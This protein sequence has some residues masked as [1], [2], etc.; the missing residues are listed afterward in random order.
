MPYAY[1]FDSL[2]DYARVAR[3]ERDV[4]RFTMP[5]YDAAKLLGMTRQGLMR[6][7]AAGHVRAMRVRPMA[8]VGF[9]FLDP[10]EV[11]AY[12]KL[13]GKFQRLRRELQGATG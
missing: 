5:L 11:K 7:I 3:H 4:D 9:I 1:D 8:G 2:K 10:Q 6:H 12:A 13:R